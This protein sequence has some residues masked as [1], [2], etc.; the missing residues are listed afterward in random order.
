M[1]LCNP[2][3]PTGK[4]FT[5]EELQTIAGFAAD[6]DLL[7]FCDETYE[8]L[9]WP[10]HRHISIGSLADARDRTVTVTSMG[11][12]YSVTGWRVG[13][14]AAEEAL[15]NEL[16]KMHDFH[17]V[18]APHPFQVA[19]ARAL[20]ELPPEFYQRLRDEY[21]ARKQILVRRALPRRVELLRAGRIVLPVVRVQPGVRGRRRRILRAAAAGGRRGRSG[22]IGILSLPVAGSAADAVHVFEI[23]NDYGRSGT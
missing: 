6:H 7:I 17:T 14:L 21:W 13:Y 2:C 10:G 3:N 20:D 1:L 8:N 5:L 16:R 19:L 9:V 22:R 18:T 12:T 23:P 4:V 15:T 11:K